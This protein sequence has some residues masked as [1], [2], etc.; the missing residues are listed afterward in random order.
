MFRL[1]LALLVATLLAA[2][3]AKPSAPQHT[4]LFDP[5]NAD[6]KNPRLEITSGPADGQDISTTGTTFAWEGKGSAYE[7]SWRCVDLYG[8]NGA[9]SDWGTGA[10]CTLTNMYEG[11]HAFEVRAKN[12][13]GDVGQTVARSF[14]VNNV[15]G[16][17]LMIYPRVL[18]VNATQ[19]FDVYCM[20]E[21]ATANV[22]SA[23]LVLQFPEANLQLQSVTAGAIWTANSGT[24]VGPY[25]NNSPGTVDVSLGV[26]G[27]HPAGVNGSGQLLKLTFQAMHAGTETISYTTAAGVRDT[28][29]GN[30]SL[31]ARTNCA[32]NIR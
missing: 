6:Y 28:L 10:S 2:G 5:D 32:V 26:A 30:I 19:T 15:N 12:Q 23:H 8:F 14:T 11:L 24:V 31:T 25:P 18:T 13:N 27:G 7:Y 29:N 22:G 1:Y 3:C 20:L 17:A 16:P 4:N 9:W 21:E